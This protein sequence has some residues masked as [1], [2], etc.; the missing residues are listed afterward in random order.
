MVDIVKNILFVVRRI[1]PCPKLHAS[2]SF[3]AA[4]PWPRAPAFSVPSPSAE[5]EMKLLCM[6]VL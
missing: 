2:T 4:I 5:A 6:C 3:F 1:D